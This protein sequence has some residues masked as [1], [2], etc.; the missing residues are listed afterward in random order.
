LHGLLEKPDLKKE[1][2]KDGR[3]KGQ[4]KKENKGKIGGKR[5][6]A[7]RDITSVKPDPVKKC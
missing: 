5:R 3:K 2:K 1:G 6:Q 7:S 4:E